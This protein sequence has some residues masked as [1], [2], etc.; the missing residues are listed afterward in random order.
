MKGTRN[1]VYKSLEGGERREKIM[2][3][4]YNIKKHKEE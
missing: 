2:K 4:Y 3:F 1:T